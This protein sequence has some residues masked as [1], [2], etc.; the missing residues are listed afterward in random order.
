MA[1]ASSAVTLWKFGCWIPRAITCRFC[2]RRCARACVAPPQHA[3]LVLYSVFSKNHCDKRYSGIW[4][5]TI[6][7]IFPMPTLITHLLGL[8]VLLRGQRVVLP[9][10]PGPGPYVSMLSFSRAQG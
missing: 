7:L 5:L 6:F 4:Q 1:S 9:A 3:A 8:L 10:G 2:T